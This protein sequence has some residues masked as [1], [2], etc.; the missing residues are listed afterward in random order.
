MNNCYNTLTSGRK[1][2]NDDR[3]IIIK[4]SKTNT[5]TE[6]LVHNSFKLSLNLSLSLTRSLIS[7]VIIII[8]Y[9]TTTII[10]T[11]LIIN[12]D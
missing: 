12:N 5:N 8:N 4:T 2:V 9:S 11:T 7:L 1:T 3:N 10:N 6:Y